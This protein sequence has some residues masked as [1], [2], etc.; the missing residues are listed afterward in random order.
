MS[1]Q[2]VHEQSPPL[3]RQL[4][5]AVGMP[6]QGWQPAEPNPGARTPAGRTDF[7]VCCSQHLRLTSQAHLP[8][9]AAWAASTHCAR[10]QECICLLCAHSTTAVAHMPTGGVQQHGAAQHGVGAPQHEH[11]ALLDSAWG[12]CRRQPTQAWAASYRLQPR[13][14]PLPH[15]LGPSQHVLC[16]R[17][18][19]MQGPGQQL[20][21]WQLRSPDTVGQ[22]CGGGVPPWGVVLLLVVTPH[23]QN[24][25][26]THQALQFVSQMPWV[27]LLW[28]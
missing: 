10:S 5:A 21:G 6:L 17:A 19:P 18:L 13:H 24:E 3:Y 15:C 4:E 1:A 20:E 8:S 27:W 11:A 12:Q 16:S 26:K 22:A 7:S 25:Q 28:S 14:A 2:L 23:L 9:P